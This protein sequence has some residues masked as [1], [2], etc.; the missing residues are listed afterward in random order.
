MSGETSGTAA[1]NAARFCLFSCFERQNERRRRSKCRS[2][3]FSNKNLANFRHYPTFA[4]IISAFEP[5]FMKKIW[6]RQ[7]FARF[8]N[9]DKRLIGDNNFPVSAGNIPDN[10]A[11]VR[12]SNTP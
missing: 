6:Q 12:H 2:F 7:I 3:L 11:D 1:Q 8:L 9:M 4:R 5:F 10:V